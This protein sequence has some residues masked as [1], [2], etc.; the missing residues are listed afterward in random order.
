[1]MKYI[2]GCGYPNIPYFWLSVRLWTC[3]LVV[4]QMQKLEMKLFK[5]LI[6]AAVI[7]IIV[8]VEMPMTS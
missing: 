6:L 7:L 3:V 1:M 2:Y 8:G 5:G 4:I